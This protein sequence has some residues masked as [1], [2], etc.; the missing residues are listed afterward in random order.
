MR[1][2][3]LVKKVKKDEKWTKMLFL[4]L[5]NYYIIEENSS[6]INCIYCETAKAFCD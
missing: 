2:L 4:I 5:K 3:S 1:E 6:C